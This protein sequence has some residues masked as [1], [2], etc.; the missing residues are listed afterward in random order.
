MKLVCCLLDLDL[1][2]LA[3]T[4]IF[5]CFVCRIEQCDFCRSVDLLTFN[6]V[7]IFMLFS[8]EMYYQCNFSNH[9]CFCFVLL[10]SDL[11]QEV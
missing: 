2:V 5:V 6:K 11:D 3:D 4:G 8:M 10:S 9:D 1:G 7:V